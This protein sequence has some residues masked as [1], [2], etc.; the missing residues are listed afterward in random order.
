MRGEYGKK[1]NIYKIEDNKKQYIDLLLLGDEQESMI[2]RYIEKGEMFVLNDEGIKAQCVVV[3]LS[4]GVYELKNISVLPEFQKKGYAKALIEFLFEHYSD[5]MTLYAGT[6]DS[7]QT[8]GFYKK[9]GFEYSHT[10]KN[11]FTDNYDHPIFENGK[12]LVDMIYL[13]RMTEGFILETERTFLRKMTFDDKK[14]LCEIL[15]DAET[16][17][18]Y[19][20]AF[21]DTETD[22]WIKRQL[23]R[24]EEDGFGLWAVIDKASGELIGQCGLTMQDTG[25]GV[26]G[27][28]VGYLFNK[29]RWHCGYATETA[30]A[31]KRYAFE[32][33]GCDRVYSII[34]DSNK[35]SQAV[36]ERNGMVRIGSFVKHYYGMDM[37]HYLYCAVNNFENTIVI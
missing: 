6:G 35:A 11:F 15:Q 8:L 37:P 29:K 28:E 32:R 26:Y 7:P 12:Q 20:H 22:D 2:D 25:G 33:L 27:V 24:Y 3:R 5:C 17:Y 10:V 19:E 14:A 1:M 36:A 16:M 21:S 9:C 23:I 31:C 34:R 30:C 18:A 13:K 4:G